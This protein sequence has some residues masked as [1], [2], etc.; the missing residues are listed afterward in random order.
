MIA[1]ERE[2]KEWAQNNNVRK[3]VSFLKKGNQK[4][5][6]NCVSKDNVS[7]CTESSGVI[8][9]RKNE[10]TFCAHSPA[11]LVYDVALSS[12]VV[13]MCDYSGFHFIF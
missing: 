13:G 4:L 10:L 3:V 11:W 1:Q 9:I 12:H 7:E 2:W 6:K 8:A 5:S